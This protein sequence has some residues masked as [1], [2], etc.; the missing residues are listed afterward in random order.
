MALQRNAL[1]AGR[2]YDQQVGEIAKLR[3]QIVEITRDADAVV[4]T[5]YPKRN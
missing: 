4:S 5:V 3:D 1:R 2:D